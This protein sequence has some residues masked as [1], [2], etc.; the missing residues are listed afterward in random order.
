MKV[1]AFF[2]ACC[3][4]HRDLLFANY[5]VLLFALNFADGYILPV[6]IT[7]NDGLH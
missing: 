7:E 2:Y 4:I 6:L 3:A 5:F 1:S